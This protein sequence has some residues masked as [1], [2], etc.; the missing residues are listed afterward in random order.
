MEPSDIL[1][2]DFYLRDAK[3]VAI[4]LLGKM[5]VRD[6]GGEVLSG[7]I[8]ETEAYFGSGDPASRAYD[9]KIKPINRWMW[10]EGGTVFIYM[11]HGNWLFNVITG[12]RGE[13][14][15]VLIRGMR[16]LKGVERMI[17][18]RGRSDMKNLTNG[19]GKLSGALKIDKSLNGLKVYDA[20]SPISVRILDPHPTFEMGHSNRIGV[21]RDLDEELRFYIVKFKP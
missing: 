14:S 16:P 1:P 21:S 3:S 18:N 2:R 8:T 13:P 19:P 17:A 4:S 15:G 11:V 12:G 10:E 7:I 20:S 9:G 5:L 6:I